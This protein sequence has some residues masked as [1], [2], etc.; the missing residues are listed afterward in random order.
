MDHPS[1][2]LYKRVLPLFFA[3]LVGGHSSKQGFN[4]LWKDRC[5]ASNGYAFVYPLSISSFSWNL[6]LS[7]RRNKNVRTQLS[8]TISKCDG[9]YRFKL[10]GES[11]H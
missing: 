10:P 11:L 4:K 9:M 8:S 7:A 6:R 2:R 5:V 3:V 1:L